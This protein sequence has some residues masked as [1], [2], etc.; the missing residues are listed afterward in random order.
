MEKKVNPKI[1]V[2]DNSSTNILLIQNIFDG[3][4]YHVIPAHSGKE[5]L[6]ILS[7]EIPDVILLDIMMPEMDGYEVL[8]KIVSNERTKDI[9]V[10]MVTAKKE[11]E[12]V[13]KALSMGALDY[14]KKPLSI[15]EILSRVNVALRLKERE[16]TIK[17]LLK[18]K[19]QIIS[20]ASEDLTLKLIKILKNSEILLYDEKLSEGLSSQQKDFLKYINKETNNLLDYVNSLINMLF[21]DSDVIPLHIQNVQLLQLINDKVLNLITKHKEKNITLEANVPAHLNVNV[22][23]TLFG[24]VLKILIEYLCMFTPSDGKVIIS[25]YDEKEQTVIKIS[26]NDIALNPGDKEIFYNEFHNSFNAEEENETEHELIIV[27]KLINAQE[28]DLT[29]NSKAGAGREFLLIL[30]K[31]FTEKKYHSFS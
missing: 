9:P 23:I 5:A 26:D 30:Q 11:T 16:D 27:K 8:E 21:S 29:I 31:C 19:K 20:T 7:K 4:N 28:L 12:D 10:I 25:A 22:D 13:K 15:V 6:D 1:L 24:N 17:R 14:I 2:V 18:S 3:S